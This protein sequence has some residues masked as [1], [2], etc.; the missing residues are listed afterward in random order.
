MLNVRAEASTNTDQIILLNTRAYLGHAIPQNV[1]KVSYSILSVLF[2]PFLR[3]NHLRRTAT[4]RGRA[5][6]G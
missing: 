3:L 1:L 6:E 4:S 2:I 5:N